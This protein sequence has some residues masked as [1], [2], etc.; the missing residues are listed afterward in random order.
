MRLE[1]GPQ[2]GRR[3]DP[4]AGAAGERERPLLLGEQVGELG[5]G[6]D[7]RLERRPAGRRER[8]VGKR[9]QLGDLAAAGLGF[10]T[11]S[12]RHGDR[13]G[14]GGRAAASRRALPRAGGRRIG[15]NG[16]EKL[17]A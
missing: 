7:P 6:G 9:G 5:G 14:N 17:T 13:N 8:P 15:V 1:A 2:A 4:G 3:L 16:A 11:T 10:S 12:H